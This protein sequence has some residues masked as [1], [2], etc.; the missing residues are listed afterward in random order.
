MTTCNKVY[1][2][3]MQLSTVNRTVNPCANL[4]NKKWCKKTRKITETLANGY[5]S[6]RAQRELSNG[7]QQDRV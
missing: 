5:S 3:I 2:V 4:A 1:K 6:G 7:Y